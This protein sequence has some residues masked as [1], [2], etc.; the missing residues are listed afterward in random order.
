MPK[1]PRITGYEAVKAFCKVGFHVARIKGSHH[2]LKHPQKP[3]IRLSIPV[4]NGQTVGV[5]LLSRQIDLAGMSLDQF[6]DL[7]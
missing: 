4:H 1:V 3:G 6:R 2:I 7:L 5:G